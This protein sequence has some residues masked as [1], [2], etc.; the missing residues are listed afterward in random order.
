MENP[1]NG[2]Y[3][4]FHRGDKGNILQRFVSL[5]IK[6]ETWERGVPHQFSHVE[7]IFPLWV[8]DQDETPNCFSSR[9]M[10]EPRGVYFKQINFSH[11]ERW[12]FVPLLWMTAQDIKDAYAD[13]K[14]LVGRGYDTRGVVSMF[15]FF[16]N[17]K[18]ISDEK[19]WCSEICARMGK[20]LKTLVSP[21]RLYLMAVERNRGIK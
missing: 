13:A 4:A 15:A 6:L 8:R 19:D 2:M 7:T 11:Q 14:T 1:V 17:H 9:G 3:Y 16:G 20:F 21:N 12:C 5:V 18:N 10:G